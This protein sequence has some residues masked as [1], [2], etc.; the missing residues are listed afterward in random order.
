MK[1]FLQLYNDWNNPTPAQ[2]LKKYLSNEDMPRWMA[3]TGMNDNPDET[4]WNT[5]WQIVNSFKMPC[6][7]SMII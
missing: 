5:E 7:P 4:A 3:L 2:I 1:T 6:N